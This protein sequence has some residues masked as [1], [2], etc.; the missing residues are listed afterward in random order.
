[1][2]KSHIIHPPTDAIITILCNV[3]IRMALLFSKAITF[4]FLFFEYLNFASPYIESMKIKETNKL[5]E[6]ERERERESS[7]G[8]VAR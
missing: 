6:R 8:K 4:T 7:V 3:S 1:M 2:Q 5:R